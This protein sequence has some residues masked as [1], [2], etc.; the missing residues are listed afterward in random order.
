MDIKEELKNSITMKDLL[1]KYGIK[2]NNMM[3][4]CPFHKDDNASAKFYVNSFY[5]FSCNKTGD[6]IQFVQTMFNINFKEAM[7]K[8]NIDFELG[9]DINSHIDRQKL[10]EI[11]NKRKKE[12]LL[13][14]Q[15]RLYFIRLC[16]ISQQLKNKINEE[17]EK[18]NVLN[19]ERKVSDIA[20]LQLKVDKINLI[21]D[22]LY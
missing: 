18:I 12:K 4:H 8:I 7:A 10:I 2:H 20:N 5:C 21:L 9:L 17:N 16:N 14:E 11:E 3:Y 22:T 15:K 19:W 6:I 13:K 1:D